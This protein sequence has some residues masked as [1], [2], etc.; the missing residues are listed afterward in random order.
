MIAKHCTVYPII[1]PTPY[2]L[3][4]FNFYL[5]EEAGSLSLIDAGVDT[6]DAWE[7]LR[8]TL[9]KHGF[10]FSDLK[11][12]LVTHNHH[13]H[14]GLI[15]RIC[16][17]QAVPVYAHAEAIPRMKR[18]PKFL[19]MRIKF[20][21]QLY[22]EMG[23]G[24]MGEKQ[25][26]KLK[27]AVHNNQHQMIRTDILPFTGSD[28]IGDFQIIETPGH[29]PDHVSFFDPKKKWLFVGDH[30]IQHISSN[31]IVEPDQQGQR[32]LTLIQYKES[33]QKCLTID[34]EIIFPG[35]GELIRN[36]QELIHRRLTRMDQKAEKMLEL[37][38]SG[39]STANQ[40]AQTLYKGKYES[41]FSLVMSEIIGHLDYLE[42]NGRIQ[43]DQKDGVWQYSPLN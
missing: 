29:A 39:L 16:A 5:V 9:T 37:L 40:L 17:Q 15:N 23:C 24:P 14:I 28:S 18:D 35:H 3:K 12:I 13:D 8:Q 21:E 19:T 38:A 31:A 2:N 1:V 7:L 34:A 4:S 36:H 10:A 30:L 41:E 22:R 6:V 11:Q 25:I 20:F 33:L 42:A 32:I 27:E 43:K 26:E